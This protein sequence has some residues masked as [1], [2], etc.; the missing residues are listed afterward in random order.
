MPAQRPPAGKPTTTAGSL[1][2]Q[3]FDP[4]N[5]VGAGHQRPETRDGG[6]GWR[7]SRAAKLRN[8]YRG[9]AAGGERM[10]DMWGAGAADYDERLGMRIPKTTRIMAANSVADMLKRPGAMKKA[11]EA[12]ASNPG[13]EAA[14]ADERTAEEKLVARRAAEDEAAAAAR[15]GRR[16]GV[17][18]GVVVYVNG[19]T[20]P[21]ISDHRLKQV[22]ADN[23][24]DMSQ[25]LGRRK[26]THVIVGKPVA[27]AGGGEGRVGCGGG[28]AGGKLEKEIKTVAGAGVK[29][30]GVEW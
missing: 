27:A 16:R 24:A 14:P 28:L 29:F 7:D 26:V 15:E 8:Q 11:M 1:Y 2:S 5:P 17:F 20:Y 3:R 4:W 10:A 25:H 18:E 22:L 30:V 6:T 23:G 13:S 12:A 9:G 19:S 21:L